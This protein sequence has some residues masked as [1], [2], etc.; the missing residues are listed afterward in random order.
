[1]RREQS[2]II[3]FQGLGVTGSKVRV[4]P[5]LREGKKPEGGGQKVGRSRR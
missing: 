2:F 5:S 4:S 1:M 3:A